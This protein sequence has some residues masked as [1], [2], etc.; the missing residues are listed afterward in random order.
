M[1]LMDLAVLNCELCEA[2][3]D[4]TLRYLRETLDCL[5]A[6]LKLSDELA[7]YVP[8]TRGRGGN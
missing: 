8:G 3:L 5:D 1:S 4:D 6:A 2:Y 7:F